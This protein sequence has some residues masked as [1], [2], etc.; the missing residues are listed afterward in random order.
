[1]DGYYKNT[2]FHRSIRNFMVCNR[3]MYRIVLPINSYDAAVLL[4]ICWWVCLLCLAV[5]FSSVVQ[6]WR[7]VNECWMEFIA[8][9]MSIVWY[10]ASEHCTWWLH[11]L[12]ND[13]WWRFYYYFYYVEIIFFHMQNKTCWTTPIARYAR[14]FQQKFINT[15]L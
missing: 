9:N 6:V 10:S 13:L 7:C 15:R 5:L 12:L 8:G 2:V 1:M 11:I 14:A 4:D 3:F